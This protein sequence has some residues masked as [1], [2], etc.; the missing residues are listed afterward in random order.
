M[1]RKA[2]NLLGQRFG[3][4][5]V[6]AQAPTMRYSRWRCACDCGAV[7]VTTS[8][9][10]RQGYTRSCGCLQRELA[11]ANLRRLHAAGGFRKQP[12]ASPAWQELAKA[13]A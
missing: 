4:L 1:G 7:C 9:M 3:R 8:S 12:V 11:R 6:I 2:I 10:L 13:M 5:V